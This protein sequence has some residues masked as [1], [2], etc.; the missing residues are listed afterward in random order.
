MKGLSAALLPLAIA[1]GLLCACQ[2][3]RPMLVA[4]PGQ[5]HAV[6]A[7]FFEQV[8]VF[9]GASDTLSP[10]SD[11]LIENGRISGFGPHGT[12]SGVA[13]A[14]AIDPQ[15]DYGR[16]AV[17]KRADLL[18]IDGDPLAD[19]SATEQ[20]AGVWQDGRRAERAVIQR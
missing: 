6:D 19:I 10:P 20:I 14:R 9:D 2:T 15:A 3:S 5:A 18:L 17:G 7:V 4:P 13:A 16:I 1:A 11:V 8:S 12:I